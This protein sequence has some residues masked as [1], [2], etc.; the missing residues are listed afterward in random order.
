MTT[1]KLSLMKRRVAL[2][3]SELFPLVADGKNWS[4]D[5]DT[6]AGFVA[7]MVPISEAVQA[8]ADQVFA[9]R[10][11]VL[12]TADRF[13]GVFA[14]APTQ[15]KDGSVLI[16]GDI[17]TDTRTPP[18]SFIWS[19]SAWD[20]IANPTEASQVSFQQSGNGAA[21]RTMQDKARERL[22]VEDYLL[23][24]AAEQTYAITQAMGERSRLGG[25]PVEL[26][27]VSYTT[28]GF[29]LPSD[30]VLNGRGEGVTTI[31]LADG[32]N[33]HVI[34]AGDYDTNADGI[35][36]DSPI[37]CMGG[38]LRNLTIDGNKANQTAAKNGIAYYGI[39]L[40]LEHVEVKNARGINI[41]VESPGATFSVTVGRALQS[42]VSHVVAHDGGIGNIFYNG[43]SDSNG[44]DI[45]CYQTDAGVGSYHLR[46]GSKASGVR[47]I[48]VH[49]WGD[50]DYSWIN[51]AATAG[52]YDSH[53]ESAAAAKVWMKA[54]GYFIGG[55]VYQ[56]GSGALPFAAPAFLIEP[57][58]SNIEI[59]T[60]I[61]NCN[62]GVKFN[63]AD[64]GNGLYFL[65]MYNNVPGASPALFSG[66]PSVT[67]TISAHLSGTVTA[68]LAQVPGTFSVADKLTARGVDVSSGGLDRVLWLAAQG[69]SVGAIDSVAG[70]VS[71]PS[72]FVVISP[73]AAV[74]I[75]DILNVSASVGFLQVT[76]RN[77]TAF[78]ATF[79]HNTGKLRNIGA[80]N[81]VLG[82]YESITYAFVSGTVW[83]QT[84]GK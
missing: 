81:K 7:P 29:A 83:Q 13:L 54:T 15:R 74:T 75:T 33:A 70:S 2:T 50:A 19:G 63:G 69:W 64:G 35:K 52:L 28:T 72:S 51:E 21:E 67:N 66:T 32:A 24:S 59:F 38:G 6:F 61:S 78:S 56:A 10:D 45:R 68:N 46:F 40:T 82:P 30:V 4:G 25:G 27:G 23:G 16:T 26:H 31:K 36:K 47:W 43:Q 62:I 55:R 14:V 12:P 53:M 8:V 60:S 84:A 48:G 57:G 39:A 11:D 20:V 65:Q 49:C 73:T 37:G 58:V 44:V 3:G 41:A 79:V 77:N 5:V 9:A 18:T 76:I 42:K 71:V 17:Y 34:T 1:N 22:S 80:V